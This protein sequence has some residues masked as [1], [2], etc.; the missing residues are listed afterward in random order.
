VGEGVID[1]YLTGLGLIESEVDANLYHILVEGKW[2]I[3]F[4]YVDDFILIGDELLIGYC[5]EN[6]ARE[7]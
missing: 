4:L 6:I 1:S 2:L 7:F 3:I 5:N